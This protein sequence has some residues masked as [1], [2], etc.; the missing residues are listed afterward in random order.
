M[1]AKPQ[2]LIFKRL[3]RQ[4]MILRTLLVMKG[5]ADSHALYFNIQSKDSQFYGPTFYG[6][7]AALVRKNLIGVSKDVNRRSWSVYYLTIEGR[8]T[9]RKL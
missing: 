8:R 3:V 9:L 5:I 6:V 2:E 4:V 7:I 1:S